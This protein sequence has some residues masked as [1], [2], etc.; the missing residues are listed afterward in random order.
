MN[1]PAL[2]III[3]SCIGIIFL[4]IW[5]YIVDIEQV[6][7]RIKN[8]NGLF[9]LSGILFYLTAYFLRAVRWRLLLKTVVSIDITKAYLTIMGGHFTNY[10]IPLRAGELMKCL[11]VKKMTGVRMSQSMPSVFLDKLYDTTGIVLVLLLLPFIKIN[12]SVYL[13][14]LLIII[15]ALVIILLA[16]LIA[17]MLDKDRVIK[18]INGMFSFL[19]KTWRVKLDEVLRY[20]VDGVVLFR[21]YKNMILPAVIL[22]LLVI[23][24]DSLF[25]LSMFWAFDKQAAFFYV[26]FGYTLIYLSFIVPHPPAQIGSNE[27]L[28]V[29]IFSVGFGMNRDIVSAIMVFAH[30]LTGLI[31]VTMGMVSYSFAGVNLLNIINRGDEFDE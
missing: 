6:L 23:L 17:V 16:L 3:S 20:F 30:L 15:I 11:F 26:L 14:Y 2:K 8:L 7:S 21:E 10:L 4:M 22:S 1:R 27:L 31:I 25:F 19:P 24:A 29:L 18:V 13:H 28:M 5:L 12:L 9:V